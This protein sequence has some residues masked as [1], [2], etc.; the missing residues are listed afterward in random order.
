MAFAVTSPAFASGKPIPR[1][2]TCEGS[3]R[4]PRLDLQGIPGGTKALAFLLE[5]PDAP[6]GLW[7][8]WTLWDVPVAASLPEGY[9]PA[10]PAREGTT[11]AGTTGYHGPCPPS[12]THRYFFR[13]WA[14]S[15]PLGLAAGAGVAEF[16]KAVASAELGSAE[17][18]GTFQRS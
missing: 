18:M 1:V 10:A 4:L 14:L 3:D 5:D 8:H 7:T 16:R 2:H 17:L 13:V 11:S 9:R 6:G 12:G 15:R